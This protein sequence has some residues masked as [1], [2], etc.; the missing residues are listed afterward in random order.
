M[1]GTIKSNVQLGDSLTATQNFTLTAAAADGTLK[2]AR[3]NAGATTQDILTVDAAGVASLLG[4]RIFSRGNILGTVSQS[5]GVPT[6]A[7]IER[8]S[9]ANGEYVRFADGTQICT[10]SGSVSLAVS[11][12]PSNGLYY[13][14]LPLWSYPSV[15]AATPFC[16]QDVIGS[17][18][19]IP[20]PGVVSAT[21]N[22]PGVGA[23]IAV[24][25]APTMYRLGA[26]GRWY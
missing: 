14:S 24:T 3:G 7:V 25:T 12:G 15:F 9:N 5:A 22:S 4:Q 26:I 8:G 1:A 17:G 23:P 13:A 16:F 10:F 6:G 2:L 19:L 18:I 20:L 11:S 21:N